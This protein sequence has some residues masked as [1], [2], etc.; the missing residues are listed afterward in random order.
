MTR[1]T[2]YQIRFTNRKGEMIASRVFSEAERDKL[3]ELLPALSCDFQGYDVIVADD[4][5][6]I[7]SKIKENFPPEKPSLK[8]L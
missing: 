7:I 8:A 6:T 2:W 3:I 4:A 5:D 1:H